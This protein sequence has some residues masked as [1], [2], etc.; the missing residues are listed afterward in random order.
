MKDNRYDPEEPFTQLDEP[1]HAWN[2]V[3]VGNDWRFVD[4]AWGAGFED[5]DGIYHKRYEEFW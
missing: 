1:E 3:Y 5:E 2:A 4:C